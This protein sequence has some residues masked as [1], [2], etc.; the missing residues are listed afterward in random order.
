MRRVDS[1]AEAFRQ[2][3]RHVAGQAAA[4][5]VGDAVDV[6]TLLAE[7]GPG[8]KHG[9]GVDPRRGQEHLAEGRECM[10]WFGAHEGAARRI[11]ETSAQDFLVRR[12]QVEIVLGDEGADQR[13]AVGMEAARG[14]AEDGVSRLGRRPVDQL[15]TLDDP[16]AAAREVEG[17]RIHDPRVLGRLAADE[18]T[19]RQ[20]AATGD[21]LDQLGHA[22]G[23]QPANRHVVEEEERRRAA[24]DDVVG[25]HRH[26][27]L[28]D[29]VVPAKGRRDGGLGS[30]TVRG[31]DEDRLA[32]P[33][34]KGDGR[35]KATEAGEHLR[36][37]G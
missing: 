26:E 6:E 29:G 4:R 20:P 23:D 31:A 17:L 11:A 34:R 1:S 30:D 25:A 3:P 7:T 15:V 13:V 22:F 2:R 18:R 19:A 24:A 5:D 9:L 16:D 12:R 35:A 21:R 36:P 28:A 27:V 33:G 14:E 37:P 8:G 32:H 10:L